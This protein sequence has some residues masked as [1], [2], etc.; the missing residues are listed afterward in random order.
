MTQSQSGPKDISVN[1]WVIV[2]SLR[3]FDTTR[4]CRDPL[5]SDDDVCKDL[6]FKILSITY[7]S[8]SHKIITE[9]V[10]VSV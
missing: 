8:R 9:V 5:W 10:E 2:K 4:F 1:G 7:V 3:L 6:N